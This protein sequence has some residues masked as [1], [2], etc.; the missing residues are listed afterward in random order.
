[1]KSLNEFYKQLS[2]LVNSRLPLPEAVK[3]MNKSLSAKVYR[4]ISSK[5]ENG[6]KLSEILEGYPRK[7]PKPHVSLIAVAEENDTLS[8][9]LEELSKYSYYEKVIADKVRDIMLYPVIVVVISFGLLGLLGK[10]MIYPMTQQ[11][12]D[13]QN[14][15]S[16]A[17]P[18]IFL[19][20]AHFVGRITHNHTVEYWIFCLT[21]SFLLIF[22]LFSTSKSFRIHSL[23]MKVSSLWTD[24]NSL[25]QSTKLSSFL[26]LQ[27]KN[28]NSIHDTCFSSQTFVSGKLQ[29]E[30]V[31]STEDLRN[32]VDMIDVFRTCSY[33]DP[34]I[35]NTLQNCPE[36]ELAGEMSAL[37]NHFYERVFLTSERLI[38]Y[39]KIIM[40]LVTA[41]FALFIAK[42]MLSPIT[43]L[44]GYF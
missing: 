5:L 42:L 31:E 43:Q 22:A 38:T 18:G 44:M 4:D 12:F 15:F 19:K 25:L 26:A 28:K 34:L 7:F 20:L 39:W 23:W 13:S 36:K 33:L 16:Y 24:L 8:E 1:M 40:T 14:Y 9:T 30:L 3:Q 29:R 11:F 2:L 6:T 35:I 10:Y 21:V 41:G 37:S 27:F 17:E 32:G